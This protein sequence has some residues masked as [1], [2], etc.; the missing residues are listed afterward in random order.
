MGTISDITQLRRGIVVQPAPATH[1][2]DASPSGKNMVLKVARL[3]AEIDS[4]RVS[5]EEMCK[6]V[7]GCNKLL[8]NLFNEAVKK[9]LDKERRSPIVAANYASGG[10]LSKSKT[11][12]EFEQATDK[13]GKDSSMFEVRP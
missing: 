12:E 8:F 10:S 13:L 7:D 11:A 4:M 5:N 1:D 2:R 3:E 9:T 6:V